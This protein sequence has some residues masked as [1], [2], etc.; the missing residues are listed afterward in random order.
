[1]GLQDATGEYTQAL[2]T[3]VAQEVKHQEEYG[4]MFD[5]MAGDIESLKTMLSD[6][7]HGEKDQ[8]FEKLQDQV[9]EMMRQDA[10]AH[11]TYVE[12]S[13]RLGKLA[14][15]ISASYQSLN[16]R[17]EQA[18]ASYK[19]TAGRLENLLSQMEGNKKWKRR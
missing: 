12:N 13:T 17:L 5:G 4:K 18:T 16:E 3:A 7:Q 19:E 8:Q 6:M 10:Q 9:S 15:E 1:M 11:C 2:N 14:E